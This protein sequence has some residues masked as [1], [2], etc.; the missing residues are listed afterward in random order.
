MAFEAAEVTAVEAVCGG[1]LSLLRVGV[2]ADAAAAYTAP[3][4]YCQVKVAGADDAAFLAIASPPDGG[5]SGE[6]EFLIKPVEGKPAGALCGLAAGDGV[7]ITAPMGKGFALADKLGDDPKEVGVL[8]LLSTGTGLAPVRALALADASRGGLKGSG[9]AD[10]RLIHGA[11]TALDIPFADDLEMLHQA[12]LEVTSTLSAEGACE[13][14]PYEWGCTDGYVQ[15]V[16][17]EARE[18]L[19]LDA[20]CAAV[21]IGQKEMF[22]GVADV[23]AKSGIDKARLCANF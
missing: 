1:S 5:E 15:D 4:Q 11:R 9:F 19:G 18:D 8:L 14:F 20:S 21:V 17:D 10:V 6:L 23:L 22:E 2:G 3:G 13:D 12:G 7:E 16:L